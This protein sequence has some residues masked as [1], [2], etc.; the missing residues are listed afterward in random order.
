[1]AGPARLTASAKVV[2]D[3]PGLVTLEVRFKLAKEQGDGDD[4]YGAD[5]FYVK[6]DKAWIQ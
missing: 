1:M 4:V 3:C 2:E 5:A 6:L